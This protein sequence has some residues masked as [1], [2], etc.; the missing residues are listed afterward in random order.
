MVLHKISAVLLLPTLLFIDAARADG[1]AHSFQHFHGPTIGEAQ[2]VTWEDE[3]GHHQDFIAH[4][5]YEYAYGVKDHRTGD[6][7][8]Q[9][10]HRDGHDVTGEYTV[11]EPTGNVRTVKYYADETGFHADVHNSDGH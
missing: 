10:E 3:H 1:H 5:K 4:P 7:H 2:A 9:K 8:G 6:Y 11:K